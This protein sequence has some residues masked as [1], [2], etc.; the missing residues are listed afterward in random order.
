MWSKLL[1]G[2]AKQAARQGALPVP[3]QEFLIKIWPTLAGE[4]L[5]RRSR[6][7]SLQEQT[8]HIEVDQENLVRELSLHP[9]PL[10][11]RVRQYSPWPIERLQF[12]YNPSLIVGGDK[13]GRP[14]RP[15]SSAAPP[16][17][18]SADVIRGPSAPGVDGEL[19]RIIDSI[20]KHRRERGEDQ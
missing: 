19:Q 20:S 10:L 1:K 13:R 17:E 8:L 7:L 12:S 9:L 18:R 3:T 4:V 16:A 15:S 5:A 2:A 11:K 6:P 14:S